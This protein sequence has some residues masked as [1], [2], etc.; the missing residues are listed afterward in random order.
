MANQ[1]DPQ[2]DNQDEQRPD[3]LPER[4]KSPEELARSYAEAERRIT[5]LGQEKSTLEQSVNELADQF[6]AFQQQAQPQQ[7]YD[8]NADP[9][10]AGYEQ[11][12]ETGDYRT[13]LAYQSQIMQAAVQQG[14]NQFAQAQQAQVGPQIEAQYNTVAALADQALGQKYEDWGEYKGKIAEAIQQSPHLVPDQALSSPLATAE[15]LDRVY[16]AVKYDDL[17]SGVAQQQQAAR[18]SAEARRLAELAPNNAGRIP[19]PEE[20]QTEWERIKA[21]GPTT[22]WHS[23]R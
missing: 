12:M 8:P 4:F 5:E 15:A 18:Q 14:I 6:E 17:V 20:N 19:T 13:A 22:P 2:A 7:Q 16:K 9:F 10:L 23:G 1:P 21:A 11:A 3:W